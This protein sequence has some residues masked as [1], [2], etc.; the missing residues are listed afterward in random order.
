MEFEGMLLNGT[1]TT[2]MKEISEPNVQHLREQP[3]L[4]CTNVNTEPLREVAWVPFSS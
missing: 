4:T 3:T 1:K 2:C